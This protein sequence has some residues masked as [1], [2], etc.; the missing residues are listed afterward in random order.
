MGC[1]DIAL[2]KKRKSSTKLVSSD[3]EESDMDGEFLTEEEEKRM[4]G[5]WELS[6]LW[7]QLISIPFGAPFPPDIHTAR[8][9]FNIIKDIQVHSNENS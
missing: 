7:D 3:L 4:D 9:D 1:N 6:F 2:K 5:H 8:T